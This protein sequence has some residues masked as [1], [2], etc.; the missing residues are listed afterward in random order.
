MRLIKLALAALFA[1]LAFSA[2][3]S[4][5]ALAAHPQF[6]TASGRTLSFKGESGTGLL[7]GVGGNTIHCEHDL[8][9]GE[10]LNASPLARNVEVEFKGNCTLLPLGVKCNEP[11]KIKLASAELG[12]ILSKR[13]VVLLLS[14]ESGTEFVE[15][16]C[17]VNKI[18]VEGAVIGEFPETNALGENQ[19]NVTRDEYELKFESEN[20]N[21][22][23]QKIK[24][25]CLLG[26]QMT[27]VG[28]STTG[29]L[30]VGEASEETT[31]TLKGDGL[32]TIDTK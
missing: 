16:V 11:I 19:Y 5:S 20:K 23:K 18:N 6:L 14:P 8:S 15:V 3:V 7:R 12:L 13:T 29:S 32:V 25:I 30:F 2:M 17:S 21:T 10:I 31:E 26:T 22:N 4:G 9:S 24:E 1:V 28:L 27:G